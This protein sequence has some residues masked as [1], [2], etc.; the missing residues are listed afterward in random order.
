MLL[1]S[2]NATAQR[3]EKLLDSFNAHADKAESSFNIED[4]LT[5]MWE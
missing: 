2:V 5:G 4:H 3:V 1:G